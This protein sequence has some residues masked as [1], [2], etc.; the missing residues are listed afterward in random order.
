MAEY[1]ERLTLLDKLDGKICPAGSGY[2]AGIFDAKVIA[3]CLPAADVRPVVRGKWKLNPDGSGTCSE[4]HFTSIAVWDCD[5]WA[6]FCQHCGAD[7]R[8]ENG[9]FAVWCG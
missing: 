8:G 7:M 9:P 6:N 5:N 3:N 2:N 1:I 4:C